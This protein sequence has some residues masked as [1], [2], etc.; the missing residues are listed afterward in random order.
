MQSSWVG[1]AA[2]HGAAAPPRTV[3]FPLAG[4]IA[5]GGG[6][7]SVLHLIQ[8]L[9]RPRYRPILAVHGDGP[10]RRWLVEQGLAHDIELLSR[11]VQ[12]RRGAWLSDAALVGRNS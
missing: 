7:V 5:V 2:P 10:V 3:C 12:S 1:T 9:D 6:H 8:H 4:D 11:R